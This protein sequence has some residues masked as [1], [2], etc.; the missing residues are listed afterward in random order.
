[1]SKRRN[2]VISGAFLALV[3]LLLAACGQ[4]GAAGNQLVIISSWTRGDQGECLNAMYEVFKQRHAKV[5]INYLA[6]DLGSAVDA[7]ALLATRMQKAEP[8]DSFQAHAG[9]EL[10]DAWVKTDQLEPV[11][12][13]FK[14]NGWIAKY[15][16][17]LIDLLSYNGE[18][19]SVPVDAQ[20]SNVLWYNKLVF[21][22]TALK[23]PRDFAEF[24]T[25]LQG[26]MKGDWQM[27]VWKGGRMDR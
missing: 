23:P 16:P 11:T 18:I 19:W 21:A 4:P 27:E 5:E 17:G 25:L 10:I 20:R 1:M 6:E 22:D 8:P 12:F 9:Q 14:D 26:E 2:W 24:F 7:A 13:L 3:G 15:P